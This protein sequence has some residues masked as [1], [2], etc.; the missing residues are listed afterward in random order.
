MI[1]TLVERLL[2]WVHETFPE[3]Q[4][5]VR[6]E[7]RVQF[8]TFGPMLQGTLAA[9]GLV[10]LGWVAFA[11]VN[12]IFKDRII[13]AKEHRYHQMQVAYENRVADLQLSYDEVHGA[14]VSAEDR[15]QSAADE[16]EVKQNT[17]LGFLG[18]KKQVDAALN[19]STNLNEKNGANPAGTADDIT[20]VPPDLRGGSDTNDAVEFAPPAK[21]PT[22]AK[23]RKSGM[24]DINGT[25]GRIAGVFFGKR[26][27]D[28]LSSET[29]A[30]HPVLKSLAVQTE[31][32][33]RLSTTETPLMADA[34]GQ[35]A[36]GVR[37]LQLLLRRASINPDKFE[38]RFAH[39][40]GGA[41]GPEI[42]LD[43]VQLEGI[44]DR[45]FQQAYLK[46]YAT[47]DQLDTLL[48]GVRHL[49][50]TAPVTGAEFY[51]NDGFGPRRDPFTGRY[52][53]HSGIDF[54]GPKGAAVHAT[55][56]GRVVF[57]G[58]KGAYGNLVEI[59]HG[60][61]IHTRYGHLMSVAVKAG[62]KVRQGA[63]IG[64]LGSTGRSTGPH[65]HYEVWYDN[66]V[67]NP[68]NFIEAG[69]YVL[70]QG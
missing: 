59:D 49:P 33:H 39:V 24:L 18:R 11:T 53:F 66:V 48:N 1:G 35:A 6:S 37:Q 28:P 50:L 64:R 4:I 52:A 46:A 23:P 15:F 16:L 17:I 31:R 14:L 41:G 26:H 34:Q 56:P 9:V 57:S 38:E 22:P 27:S 19:G 70:K 45:N 20:A 25:V 30:R 47:L 21:K 2:A 43:S 32:L 58:Y 51:R 63:I 3:K 10:F 7:G 36:K 44:P 40:E 12:V 68:R 61:G 54:D 5:Y 13:A 65:V 60:Y 42:P 69:R 55:A 8:F 62:A 67:R 29:V